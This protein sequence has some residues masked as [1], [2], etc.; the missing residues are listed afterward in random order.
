MATAAI[1]RHWPQL[2]GT[3]RHYTT[4]AAITRHWPPLY[5]SGRHYTTLAVHYQASAQE[6]TWARE[7]CLME[8]SQFLLLAN[9]VKQ[10]NGVLHGCEKQEKHT[11]FWS[12]N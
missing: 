12:E 4:L 3:G 11:K 8:A 9:V 2:H 5:G 7:N 6:S 10:R 1:T